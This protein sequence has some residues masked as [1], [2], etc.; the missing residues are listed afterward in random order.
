MEHL[1]RIWDRKSPRHNWQV[2]ATS[3]N[4]ARIAAL[5]AVHTIALIDDPKWHTGQIGVST[6]DPESATGLQTKADCTRPRNAP[7]N[8]IISIGDFI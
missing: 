1:Q 2:Y 6:E 8:Q 4:P 3:G 7:M 5:I